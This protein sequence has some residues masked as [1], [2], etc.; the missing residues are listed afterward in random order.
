MAFCSSVSVTRRKAINWLLDD[1]RNIW[2][3]WNLCENL[4]FHPSHSSEINYFQV[5]GPRYSSP[6]LDVLTQSASSQSKKQQR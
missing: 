4:F 5:Q 6:S 3:S 2:L 1:D